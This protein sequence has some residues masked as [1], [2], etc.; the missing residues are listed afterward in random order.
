MRTWT[1]LRPRNSVVL[2]VLPAG[3]SPTVILPSP[4]HRLTTLFQGGAI[5]QLAPD[6]LRAAGVGGREHRLFISYRRDD[7]QELAEELHDELT[8]RGFHVF[9]D[10]FRGIAGTPFPQQ[11]QRELADKGVVLVIE[12]PL[13]RKSRWTLREVSMA[14]A[15][16]L[17]LLALGLPRAPRFAAIPPIDRI[18]PMWPADWKTAPSGRLVL[19][20]PALQSV[21]EFVR[22]RYAVHGLQRQL[23]LENLLHGALAPHNLAAS[24]AGSGA[25]SVAAKADY[26]VQLSPRLPELAE[27]RQA[28][29]KARSSNAS[30]V[31]VGASRLLAPEDAEDLHWTAAE[32]QV[33]MRPER[34]LRRLA[35]SMARGQVPP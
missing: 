4:L 9:L 14:R 5:E 15:M 3:A 1:R 20:P 29:I 23:Y 18:E 13:I 35:K 25:F 16:R 6:V 2:P 8:H 12:S 26:L 31:V 27:L 7:A 33:V 24:Y 30:A 28:A 10:R 32:L 17:G 34:A 19:T 11:L 21:V 22:S